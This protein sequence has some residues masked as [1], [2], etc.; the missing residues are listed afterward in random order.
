M[1]WCSVCISSGLV[2]VFVSVS[3]VRVWLCGIFISRLMSG[4][5]GSCRLVMIS[6]GMW[7]VIVI[8]VFVSVLIV[9]MMFR[10][11]LV[12]MMLSVCVCGCV[13]DWMMRMLDMNVGCGN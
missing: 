3:L 8:W 10:C 5:L 4:L 7:C 13:L 2:S 6:C 9:L 11:G 12:V 1:L